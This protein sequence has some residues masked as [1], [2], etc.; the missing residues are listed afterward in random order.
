MDQREAQRLKK[1][2]RELLE[3]SRVQLAELERIN[4]IPD[5]AARGRAL[6]EY[7]R[8]QLQLVPPPKK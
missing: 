2:A 1:A 8:V 5:D 7:M 6:R 4:A 3:A